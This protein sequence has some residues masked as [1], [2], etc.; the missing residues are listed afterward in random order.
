M[1]QTQF[2]HAPAGNREKP[3]NDSD[4]DLKIIGCRF[5]TNSEGIS[6]GAVASSDFLGYLSGAKSL[7]D[8]RGTACP[9]KGSCCFALMRPIQT[10]IL[11]KHCNEFITIDRK[12]VV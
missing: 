11:G 12:S 10:Y 5:G 4:C 8:V 1:G 7:T 9:E 2:G 6:D 3:G